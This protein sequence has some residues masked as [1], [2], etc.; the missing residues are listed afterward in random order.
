M[1]ALRGIFK[2]ACGDVR[3]EAFKLILF[4]MRWVIATMPGLFLAAYGAAANH[5][6]LIL[7]GLIA[8]LPWPLAT[9]GLFSWPNA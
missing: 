6:P 5:L 9:F 1:S 3:E 7:L 8:L 2:Q 4:N